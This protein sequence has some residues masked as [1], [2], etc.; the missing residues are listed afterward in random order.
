MVTGV[1]SVKSIAN[2][3]SLAGGD[4]HRTPSF[5]IV[6]SPSGAREQIHYHLSASSRNLLRAATIRNRH[7]PNG[8]HPR[9]RECAELWPP[10][11]PS[12]SAKRQ[13]VFVLF[14]SRDTD[15]RQHAHISDSGTRPRRRR[16]LGIDCYVEM[17]GTASRGKIAQPSNGFSFSGLDHPAILGCG[18]PNAHTARAES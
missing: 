9:I 3:K 6:R 17:S 8:R 4:S 16:R 18:D 1:A 11:E 14:L 13:A 7:L 5:A 15:Q 10:L 12:G 2:D